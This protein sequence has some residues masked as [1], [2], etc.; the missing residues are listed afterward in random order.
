MTVPETK[1][2]Y[3]YIFSVTACE[4]IQDFKNEHF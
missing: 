4:I 3:L 1:V 2:L